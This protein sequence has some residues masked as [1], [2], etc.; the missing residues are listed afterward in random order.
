[1]VADVLVAEAM[2]KGISA[3]AASMP[4]AMHVTAETGLTDLCADEVS[5]GDVVHKRA[6][7]AGRSAVG[8]G[9]RCSTAA[10]RAP[11]TLVEALADIYEVVIVST[12]RIGLGSS[13]P[14]FAGASRAGWWSSASAIRPRR[15]ST[16]RWRD[17]GAL[18]FDVVQRVTVPERRIRGRL[19]EALRYAAIR[20]MFELLS[21]TRLTALVRA[22]VEGARRHLHA[23]PCRC[24]TSRRTSRP[25]P[26]C[27]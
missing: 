6:R 12:G 8:A 20:G 4:A 3:S 22:T 10:P 11:L 21:A 14:L 24:P 1:M 7:R 18:G 9:Q 15:C 17:V 16:P 26:S 19:M 27:R 2:H 25:T 13:L 5:F 23:A